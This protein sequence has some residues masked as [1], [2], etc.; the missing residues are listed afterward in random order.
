M[1]DGSHTCPAGDCTAIV[2]NRLLMCSR[3]WYRVP[4]ALR[5][6]VSRAYRDNGLGSLQLLRAQQAAI[7]AVGGTGKAN[8]G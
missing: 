2:D 1:A 4:R 3:D 6:A 5:N 8:R 7:R